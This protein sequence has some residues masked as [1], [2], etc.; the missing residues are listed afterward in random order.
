MTGSGS[1]MYYANFSSRTMRLAWH[2]AGTSEEGEM[3]PPCVQSL[4]DVLTQW[5]GMETAF[6]CKVLT[7]DDTC[8]HQDMHGFTRSVKDDGRSA[9]GRRFSL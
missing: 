2:S 3:S 1:Y 4:L 5:H 6:I 7:S 9:R 8:C